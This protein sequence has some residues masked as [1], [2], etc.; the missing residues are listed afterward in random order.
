ML[1]AMYLA[2]VVDYYIYIEVTEVELYQKWK[3]N[4]IVEF[5]KFTI[6]FLIRL[7]S[8]IQAIA[9]IRWHQNDTWYA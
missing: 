8:T 7:S 2:V 5:W 6:Y 1:H 3:D 4:N 9:N